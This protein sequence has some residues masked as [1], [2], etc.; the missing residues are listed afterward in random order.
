MASVNPSV[1]V[2]GDVVGSR[3]VADRAALH[4]RLTGALAEV[5]GRWGTDLRITVG[6]E[7][8]G[9]VPTLGAATTVALA[10]RLALLPAYDVRHGIGRGVAAVLDPDSGIEDGPGWWAART[11]IDAAEDR[12]RRAATRSSRT[13]FRSA[14]P[15]EVVGPVEAALLAR[16]ELVGRLDDRS[17]SV[18]RG[19]LA[20][21]TQRELAAGLGVS[22]SAV[23]Q[24]VRHD[25]LGVVLTMSEWLEEL[26]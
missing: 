25:A 9:T 16:D 2:I 19:L 17:L 24:R 22:G 23:S 26:A 20:G 15:A 10:L 5:N 12:A 11:A 3:T 21:R 6:D 7:Y 14:D 4:R 13:A 8:Q 18:L 1:L